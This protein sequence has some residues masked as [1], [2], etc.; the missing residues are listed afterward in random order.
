MRADSLPFR[1][2]SRLIPSNLGSA[3]L[4]SPDDDASRL[5]ELP[6]F[7]EQLGLPPGADLD[8]EV[9]AAEQKADEEVEMRQAFS[10]PTPPPGVH[11]GS[12]AYRLFHEEAYQILRRQLQQ[13]QHQ[14]REYN[15]QK[16]Q[17]LKAEIELIKKEA[18]SATP[19]PNRRADSA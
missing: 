13:T 18:T 10:V 9:A 15:E 16:S 3:N 7:E 1:Q 19:A 11:P 14:L 5:Q 12:A 4:G 6:D 2:T 8:A 17:K